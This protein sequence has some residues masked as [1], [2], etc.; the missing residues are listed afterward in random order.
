MNTNQ[1]P[2]TT[3]DQLQD[4]FLQKIAEVRQMLYIR[5]VCQ[6]VYQSRIDTLCELFGRMRGM[7]DIASHHYRSS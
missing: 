4:Q 3:E 1:T 5:D 6:D 2:L 7:Y